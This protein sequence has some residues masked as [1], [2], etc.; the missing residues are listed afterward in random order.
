M[1]ALIVLIAALL[2]CGVLRAQ[3]GP[4][5]GE[6]PVNTH[7]L[8]TQGDS[9]VAM[10]AAGNFVV[11]WESLGQ[12]GSIPPSFNVYGRRYDAA[13][14]PLGGEFL[15]N[16][17]T[18]GNQFS[19]AIAMDAAGGFVVA[20][21]GTNQDGSQ[22][23]VAA[24]S[25]ASDGTPLGD[26]FTVNAHT[27]DNQRSVSLAM[28]GAGR[29]VVVWSSFGQDGA[30]YGVFARR[31]SAAGTPLSGEFQV[32]AST[33]SDQ[34]SG[35][36]AVTSDPA[37]NLVVAW[38]SPDG[39][40]AGIYARRFDA[41]NAPRG[42]EM[43]V[44]A[45]T[46]GRQVDPSVVSDPLGNFVVVWNAWTHPA[47]GSS[48]GVFGQ[49]YTGAGAA[50]GGE[51][52]VNIENYSGQITGGIAM[53]PSGNFTVV[54]YSALQ[55]GD[56][57]GIFGRRYAREQDPLG[58]GPKPLGGE[59]QVNSFTTGE[60]NLPAIAVNATGDFVVTW[61]SFEQDGDDQGIFGQRFH[62]D[63][64]P[65]MVSALTVDLAHNGTQ[66]HFGWDDAAGADDYVVMQDA[67]AAGSF[68]NMTGTAPD[69]A[70]GLMVPLPPG[71]FRYYLVAGRNG[72]CGY[73][74]L[75]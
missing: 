10:D 9:A 73:G 14:F 62:C 24:R 45:F 8:H 54:W 33:L 60:Q 39:S 27:P 38:E 15:I 75:R 20:W 49:R 16:T 11:V 29:F 19:P 25:F 3:N 21:E 17:V 40:A 46:L 1:R 64:I 26:Q 31:F 51:F 36:A 12:D 7:T 56:N 67:S 30:G 52:K 65:G 43:R 44:N 6:F 68:M 59:F 61:Y 18:A 71:T 48:W 42:G 5:G 69:G 47:D 2:S 72:S 58:P 41:A 23:G 53:E 70:S 22:Y 4:V 57:L 32:N 50:L 74:P 63:P 13:G 28:D 34:F 55:D 37:G 35:G 66:L